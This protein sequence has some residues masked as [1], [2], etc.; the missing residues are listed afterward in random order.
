M[1]QAGTL[2]WQSALASHVQLPA[3]VCLV[4]R[5]DESAG[6]RLDH[7]NALSSEVLGKADVKEA[8]SDSVTPDENRGEAATSSLV[9]RVR[10]AVEAG[11][12]PGSGQGML[13]GSEGL[14]HLGVMAVHA[15]VD[16]P[17]IVI[18]SAIEEALLNEDIQRS[19]EWSDSESDGFEISVDRD[20]STLTSEVVPAEIAISQGGGLETNGPHDLSAVR[21]AW[22]V[23]A[24]QWPIVT[25]D[26]V[27]GQSEVFNQLWGAFRRVGSDADRLA[28]TSSLTGE[29]RST[30]SIGLARW[31]AG[32]GYTTLLV[33]ADFAHGDLSNLAGL[34]F[35]F[36]WQ[37]MA[38]EAVPVEE[39]L[40]SCD[41]VPLTLMCFQPA[42]ISDGEEVA[43]A[44]KLVEV[45][46]GLRASFDVIILD[47][48]TT[49]EIERLF[50]EVGLPA[51]LGIIVKGLDGV[52]ET[53]MVH[54]HQALRAV[55]LQ[56]LAIADN[57]GHRYAT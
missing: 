12:S 48:G 10:R 44:T 28:V 45:I 49:A 8:F 5:P 52:G 38:A 2:K 35:E 37:Q 36:G 34:E 30:L 33:D 53:E 11:E 55:G 43:A 54:A 29:G 51:D 20:E 6:K 56:H 25:T 57:F 23:D 9:D 46:N 13:S 21:A 18:V 14:G 40:V 42:Q 7:G 24:F 31:A 15:P 50:S 32:Q 19:S 27:Q 17:E 4:A 39:F 3:G 47:C 16:T 26:L 1:N 41:E 22:E